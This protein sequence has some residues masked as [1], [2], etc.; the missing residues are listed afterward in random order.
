[1]TRDELTTKATQ[2]SWTARMNE[3]VHGALV[4]RYLAH[5]RRV[6]LAGVG[7]VLAVTGFLGASG[8]LRLAE[9]PQAAQTTLLVLAGTAA[10]AVALI[11][12]YIAAFSSSKVANLHTE[13]RQRWI[14]L[15]YDFERLAIELDEE[16]SDDPSDRLRR[17]FKR[18]QD[19]KREI[20]RAEPAH[21]DRELIRWARLQVLEEEGLA[22]Q[23]ETGTEPTPTAP[24]ATVPVPQQAAS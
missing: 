17:E 20:S 22:E 13:L 11:N 21:P 15:R 18:L 7:A 4:D 9:A 24:A 19:R 8:V 5:D 23:E 12:G 1:M 2:E 14:G 3:K 10:V 16:S 6:R